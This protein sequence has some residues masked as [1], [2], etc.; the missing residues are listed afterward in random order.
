MPGDSY[1][2]SIACYSFY[3]LPFKQNV[4]PQYLETCV[5]FIRLIIAYV[6]GALLNFTPGFMI[7]MTQIIVTR[8]KLNMKHIKESLPLIEDSYIEEEAIDS[9]KERDTASPEPNR[10]KSDEMVDLS[11]VCFQSESLTKPTTIDS[12]TAKSEPSPK[13]QHQLNTRIMS[14]EELRKENESIQAFVLKL[15]SMFCC[16]TALLL[17]SSVATICLAIFYLGDSDGHNSMSAVILLTAASTFLISCLTCGVYINSTAHSV[18]LLLHKVN[19]S[20]LPDTSHNALMLF[21]GDAG[22]KSVGITACGLFV[23]DGGAVMSVLSCVLTY[24]VLVFQFSTPDNMCNWP[25]LN[26]TQTHF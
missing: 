14:I 1:S 25:P 13:S 22:L 20:S 3:L 23:V 11:D 5:V 24:T 10:K 26:N 19:V 21:A 17:T 4:L 12:S 9:M 18:S 16:I 2:L 15:D 7:I 6:V 8:F